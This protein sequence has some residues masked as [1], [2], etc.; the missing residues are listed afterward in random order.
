MRLQDRT[1]LF[2]ARPVGASV[3][4]APAARP[5]ARTLQGLS[6]RACPDLSRTQHAGLLREMGRSYLRST[7]PSTLRALERDLAYVTDWEMATLR[8]PR[9]WPDGE[10]VALQDDGHMARSLS[11]R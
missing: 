4:P 2:R 11:S 10:K 6:A 9:A 5:V 7:P 3:W 8:K 1:Q